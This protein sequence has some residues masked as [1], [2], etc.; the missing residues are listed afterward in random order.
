MKKILIIKFTLI[1]LVVVMISSWNNIQWLRFFLL[2][3]GLM[4]TLIL[5]FYLYRDFCENKQEKLTHKK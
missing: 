4:A 1:G 5:Y 3:W 2:W